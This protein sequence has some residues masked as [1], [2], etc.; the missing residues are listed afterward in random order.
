MGTR[1]LICIVKDNEYK[2][3]Q[4]GQWDG[5]PS[6][7]GIDILEFLNK[8]MDRDVFLKKL[9]LVKPYPENDANNLIKELG[10]MP[11]YFSRD[12]GAKILP[13]I[14]NSE[15]EI[16]TFLNKDFVGDSLFCEWAWVIDFDKNTFEVYKGFNKEHVDPT[17]R[18]AD[19]ATVH[20][21]Y[22]QVRHF[23]TFDLNN[24]P[25]ED[26][27]LAILEPEEDED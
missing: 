17:E 8:E 10:R 11:V 5:Y 6:G 27:F 7:Q 1:H 20:E 2:L 3:A 15:K 16:P 14:Q 23:H 25:D 24:L 9:D 4:Y 13:Y 12:T 26:Q 19:V 18:F 21:E 22:K